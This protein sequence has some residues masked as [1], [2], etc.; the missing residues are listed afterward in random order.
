VKAFKR[1]PNCKE[2]LANYRRQYK[3]RLP[4]SSY[5]PTPSNQSGY[6][7]HSSSLWKND[8]VTN[9]NR[10]LFID[11]CRSLPEVTFEGG[12]GPLLPG[13]PVSGFEDKIQERRYTLGEWMEKTRHSSL[14]F[15]TPAVYSCHGWKL[16]EYLALGKAIISTAL[17]R[18]LPAPL[19]HGQHIHYVAAD[20][21]EIKNAI[22]RIVN[23]HEYRIYLERN[24]RGYYDKYLSPENSIKSIMAEV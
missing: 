4:E 21:R 10:A 19:I 22:E 2:Y 14:V 1:I 16:P 15:N 11:V 18:E 20:C 6:I 8:P 3:Y 9:S 23:D 7:F 12:F 24:A 17:S 5:Y 13:H